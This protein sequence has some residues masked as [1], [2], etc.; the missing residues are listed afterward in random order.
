MTGGSDKSYEI[1]RD[2]AIAARETGLL[3]ASGSVSAG[4]KHPETAKAIVS[5]VKC[6]T[7]VI[8]SLI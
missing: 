8:Y 1:N 4:L 3:M 7:T 2:L 5:F 6:T